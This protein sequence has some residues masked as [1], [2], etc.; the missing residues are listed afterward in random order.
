M[1]QRQSQLVAQLSTPGSPVMGGTGVHGGLRALVSAPAHT[2]IRQ[3]LENA[4][5]EN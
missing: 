5:Q 3:N 4:P 1:R 2:T